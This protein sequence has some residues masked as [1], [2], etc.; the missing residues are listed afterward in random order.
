[1]HRE[2]WLRRFDG[3][4]ARTIFCFW[5]GEI[6]QM[7]PNR[8][9]SLF[10]LFH[11]TGCSICLITKDTL[12]NWVHP[13]HPLISGFDYLSDVHK[14]DYLRAYFMH[15]YGGGYSDIKPP[16][17][18]WNAAFDIMQGENSYAIGYRELRPTCV[19]ST[20]SEDS[21]KVRDAYLELIGMCAYIMRK[22]TEL[23]KKYLFRLESV[24]LHYYP[25]LR[26]G[27]PISAYDS[28]DKL[29]VSEPSA[30][31]L[32]WTEIGSEVFHP[33]CYEL[34]EH[35]QFFDLLCPNLTKEYR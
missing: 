26:A 23:T 31:P 19:A 35:L 25:N 15:F 21:L 18:N 20:G 33:T 30:Y 13:D 29:F 7:S 24:I 12:K 27:P 28:A 1:M 2:I 10:T 11:V 6:N 5:F 3:L 32:R 14:S 34:R 22:R 16:R 9:V 17:T 4:E 8:L